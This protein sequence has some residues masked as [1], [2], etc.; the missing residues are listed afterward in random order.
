MK[1][2]NPDL[3][4]LLKDILSALMVLSVIPI[5]WNKISETPPE[6]ERSFWAFPIVGL[7]LGLLSSF[8]FITL[9]YLGV[10]IIV[11]V[12][13]AV[14]S[15]IIFTGGLHEEGFADSVQA[16][17]EGKDKKKILELMKN[18]NINAY[19]TLA[20][21]LLIVIK[22]S[23]LTS[24]G[25]ENQWYVFSAIVVS[26]TIGRSMLVFLRSISKQISKNTSNYEKFQTD[27]SVLW[28]ALGISFLI[29]IIFAPFWVAIVGYTFCIIQ[30]YILMA[31]TNK[32]IGGVT[33]G[34]LGAN[35]QI[36]EIL[37]LIIFSALYGS[38]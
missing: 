27:G 24:L 5:P 15:S 13:L 38:I 10:P 36:T 3:L 33:G 2:K 34:I 37:F 26:S 16:F 19:G 23:T 6:F 4:D 31:Y 20:L 12:T 14:I 29:T 1:N 17:K 28:S 18:S 25:L 35:E 30:S 8:I 7:I 21:I 32:K 11:S 9:Y 22:I